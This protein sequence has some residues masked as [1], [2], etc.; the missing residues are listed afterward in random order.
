[1]DRRQSWTQNPESFSEKM[2]EPMGSQKVRQLNA[3]PRE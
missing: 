2:T 3:K 1:M